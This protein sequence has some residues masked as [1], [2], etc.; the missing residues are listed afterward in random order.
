MNNYKPLRDL[1]LVKIVEKHNTTSGIVLPQNAGSRFVELKVLGMGPDVK[2]DI[3]L[4][5]TVLAENMVE[6][7]DRE[8]VIGL[9]VSKYIVAV[10]V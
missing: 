2:E 10:N 7:I 9:I 3:Q 5:D 8:K 6:A 4:N 1:L